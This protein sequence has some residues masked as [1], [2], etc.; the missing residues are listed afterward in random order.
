[1]TPQRKLLQS[2]WM[3]VKQ[4]SWTWPLS[5]RSGSR[6]CSLNSAKATLETSWPFSTRSSRPTKAPFLWS[7]L[8][9]PLPSSLSC[10]SKSFVWKILHRV[11]TAL[12]WK[13]RQPQE[14][15]MATKM[16]SLLDV[17]LS[18]DFGNRCCSL[19]SA[20]AI[21]AATLGIWMEVWRIS[22]FPGTASALLLLFSAFPP[23]VFSVL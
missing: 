8:S 16:K 7:L 14:M 21:L 20:K 1:M 12:D 6:I 18:S 2:P 3:K 4:V 11:S 22:K 17:P 9:S 10:V 23:F 13:S 5:T 15:S 19:E